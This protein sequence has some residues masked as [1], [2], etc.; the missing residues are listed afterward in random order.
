MPL[1]RAKLGCLIGSVPESGERVARN[2]AQRWT[3]KA[4]AWTEIAAADWLWTHNIAL[5]AG[6]CCEKPAS[7]MGAV[8]LTDTFV[9]AAPFVDAFDFVV[10]SSS[11]GERMV[12]DAMRNGLP[13]NTARH[14]S[15]S[16]YATAT[17]STSC[18]TG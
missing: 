16:F 2:F 4:Q 15:W 1:P 6:M 10:P 3:P 12:E 11:L 7:V 13:A 8:L 18:S 14:A 9:Q 5:L 17:I